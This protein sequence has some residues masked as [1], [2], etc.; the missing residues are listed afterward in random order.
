[1]RR[2]VELYVRLTE[3]CKAE[4]HVRMVVEFQ[5]DTE[6]QNIMPMEGG[7]RLETSRGDIE[8]K[9]VVNAAGVYAD[10]FHNMV[11]EDKI[12]IIPRKGEYCLM[13]KKVGGFCKEYDLP[14]SYKIR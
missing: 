7:Y 10:K 11:S 4:K 8:A 6:V 13:D 14:A 5:F 1:M 3:H 9:M 2:L 12:E